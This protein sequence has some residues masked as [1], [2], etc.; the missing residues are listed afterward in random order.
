VRTRKLRFIFPNRIRR[1][2]G[3]RSDLG[4]GGAALI[5]LLRSL[6]GIDPH[7]V[8]PSLNFACNSSIGSSLK[9]FNLTDEFR[10]LIRF[11]GFISFYRQELQKL[12]VSGPGL[13]G[14]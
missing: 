9:N 14:R 4:T 5:Q 11:A 12:E 3:A 8:M 13:S 1:V 10:F 2:A 7:L 6:I